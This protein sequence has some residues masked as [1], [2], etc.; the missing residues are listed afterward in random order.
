MEN[1]NK[2][3]VMVL[4]DWSEA[5]LLQLDMETKIESEKK[6][7]FDERQ[8]II[9]DLNRELGK[10]NG[11]FDAAKSA[12]KSFEAKF[13]VV[14]SRCQDL[15]ALPEQLAIA[16]AQA[17]NLARIKESQSES[18]EA[19]RIDIKAKREEFD[20][21]VIEKDDA[22]ALAKGDK[23]NGK[24]KKGKGR[25]TFGKGKG[26]Y[27]VEGYWDAHAEAGD[28]LAWA[29]EQWKGDGIED[30]GAVYDQDG[31]YD[32]FVACIDS[33]CSGFILRDIDIPMCIDCIVDVTEDVDK[34]MFEFVFGVV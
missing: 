5:K 8:I 26:L 7:V 16:T 33:W 23:G 25:G 27:G 11:R 3:L 4:K 32:E 20:L 1:V 17:E 19:Q 18:I 29:E 14:N 9:D 12:L 2:K 21:K 13:E 6:I 15:E 24:G 30:A 22:I 10:S 28:P 31:M 34:N